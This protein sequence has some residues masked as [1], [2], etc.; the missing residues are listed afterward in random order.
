L[1]TCFIFI[2]PEFS[3]GPKR[4]QEPSS[5]GAN[6][7]RDCGTNQAKT[8]EIPSPSTRAPG[9]ASES[10]AAGIKQWP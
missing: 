9:R 2:D 8:R 10:A 4:Q 6:A 7:L 1:K 3:P 5:A